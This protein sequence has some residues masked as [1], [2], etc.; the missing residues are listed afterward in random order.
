MAGADRPSVDGPV[1]S[2]APAEAGGDRR[3]MHDL[4]ERIEA[5][6]YSVEPGLVAEAMLVR[7]RRDQA[8]AVLVAAQALDL[9]AA[10]AEQSD[11]GPLGD[12][13]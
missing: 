5:G 1:T 3:H 7:I 11:A 10:G 6:T 8:S 4:R 12:P 2:V 13:A 9:D